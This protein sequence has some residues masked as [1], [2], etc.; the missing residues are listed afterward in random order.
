MRVN[1]TEGEIKYLAFVVE[2]S[3]DE[4]KHDERFCD[5][6]IL[7]IDLKDRLRELIGLEIK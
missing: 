3:I 7:A 6:V 2:Q 1:L 4:A 5:C